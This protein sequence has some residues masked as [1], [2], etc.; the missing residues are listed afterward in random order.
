MKSNQ[1][2]LRKLLLSLIILIPNLIQCSDSKNK[3][4]HIGETTL[5]VCETQGEPREVQAPILVR[6]YPASWD[7]NWFGSPAFADLDGDG[8]NEIIAGR[9]S[10]LYVWSVDGNLLWRAPMGQDAS[11]LDDHA[12]ARQ[13]AAPA[14]GDFDNDGT[15]E[16]AT[17]YSHFIAVYKHDGSFAPGWP[18]SFPNAEHE[19]RSVAAADLDR[20]GYWE[21][22]AVKT[23][24]GP[25]TVVFDYQGRVLE[26]WPQVDC[27]NCYDHGGYNQNIGLADITGDGNLEVIATYDCAYIGFFKHNGEALAAHPDLRGDVIPSV[28]MF[29]DWALQVQGWGP[30]GADRDEFTDS[31]PVFG[32]IDGDGHLEI[33]LYSDHERAGEYKNRGNCLW[34]LKTDL[35]RVP[36][37]EWPI[38][39]GDPLFEGYENNIVQVAP[40]P[41]V[42]NIQGD[43]RPEIIVPSYD[44]LM[45][46]YSPDGEELWAVEFDSPKGAFI[47]ASG[48]VVADLNGDG[49]PEVMFSTYA[50]DEGRSH[51]YIVSANGTVL[52]KIALE[53]R[54]SMSPPTI[55]DVDGDGQLDLL[56]SLKDTVGGGLGGVQLWTIPN[57]GTSCILWSTG[58]GNMARTG[59]SWNP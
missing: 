59:T 27:E 48:A 1:L 23:S 3:R 46:A 43:S 52:H 49:R 33:I 57:A 38:C 37:F 6:T 44:G 40:V 15:L 53:K 32:D 19:I 36:G 42:A 26:G 8:Q 54:G 21:I 41:A 2:Y 56:I 16:I 31:P 7:E 34:V 18:A 11:S 28:P 30:D 22:A 5:P 45:R 14:I 24:N 20:D 25:V 12:S 13:Y 17:A 4:G 29:H 50:M 35:S 9:H 47:G 51:L 58:R 10:V 55:G 39:S